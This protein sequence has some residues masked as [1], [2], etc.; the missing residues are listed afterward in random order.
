M[1]VN[2]DHDPVECGHSPGSARRS[3][4]A[5]AAPEPPAGQGSVL[6]WFESSP[7]SAVGGAAGILVVMVAGV[8]VVQGFSVVWMRYWQPW[9]ILCAMALLFYFFRRRTAVSAGAE[10][11]QRRGGRWVRTHELSSVTAHPGIG[12]IRLHLVDYEGRKIR[13]SNHDLQENRRVWELV[14][15]GIVQSVIAGG[16][17][18]NG[19][20]HRAFEIPR[21]GSGPAPEG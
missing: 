5:V 6:A 15:E 8:I 16:A 18:T 10:W 19:L 4:P 21:P 17:R 9:L 7:R 3:V 12:S 11:L 13:V 2:P 1:S 14:H 20:L